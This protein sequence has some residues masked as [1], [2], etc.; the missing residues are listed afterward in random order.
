MAY[1]FAN[2]SID[3]ERHVL[4]RQNKSVHVE[5]QVFEI[6][7]TLA[8]K[9]G[10]LVTKD[11]LVESVW[12]GLNVSDATISA[13]INAARKAVGDT[14][15]EQTIIK[16]VH[17]RGFQM[18]AE[19]SEVPSPAAKADTIDDPVSRQ[20]IRFAHSSHD[21]RI[22][23]ARSGDGP[24]LVRAGHW[25]SHLELDWHSSV[26]RPLIEALGR[27]HTL[28][29]YDQRGTGLSSRGLDFADL[30]A[31]ADDLKAVADANDLDRFPIFAASQAVPVAIRFAA[32]HPERVSGL[33][34]YGGYAEGR[35]LRASSPGDI[36]E[37]TLLALIRAGWGKAESPFV[38]AF[39]SL[40]LPDATTEQ[41]D[42]FVR[43]QTETI[44]PENAF[45]LRRIVDRFDVRDVL[46]TISAPTLVI[47]ANSDAVQPVQQG[48]I[49][50]SEIPNA[51]YVSLESRNHIP[52]PQEESW[53]RMMKEI[54]SFIE[55]LG[56]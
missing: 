47:H 56:R 14:G 16:T 26:W 40:F 25:L 45:R 30:D 48:R 8:R 5:P 52:L 20:I 17:G 22:A 49:L 21:A 29:R 10:R 41:M 1:R 24:P 6:L 9:R 42:G 38:N 43:M 37:D 3:S 34:L 53:M 4:L 31:F 33:V 15:R 39:S 12:R 44:S 35:A 19:V 54:Q 28:Y 46:P 13:R 50:A 55:S 7:L 27:D 51:S 2:C 18:I 36:D 11:E 23:F 32:R